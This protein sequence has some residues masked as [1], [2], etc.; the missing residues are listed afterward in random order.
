MLGSY[1]DNDL[2]V[3]PFDSYFLI[4]SQNKKI[5]GEDLEIL[6]KI[7]RFFCK[8]MNIKGTVHQKNENSVT[9]YSPSCRSKP[10]RHSFI[11]GTQIK[12]FF[13]KSESLQ[14]LHRQQRN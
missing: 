11:F 5:H 1:L 14:T 6:L 9:N 7:V 2:N 4:L 8:Y 13:I 10:V 12:I 3:C